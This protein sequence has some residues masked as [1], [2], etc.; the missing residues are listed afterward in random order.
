VEQM[1]RRNVIIGACVT[2]VSVA[3]LMYMVASNTTVVV[4]RNGGM[5]TNKVMAKP[6]G[7]EKKKEGV[8]TQGPLT[9][10]Q[11]NGVRIQG[12]RAQ[13]TVKVHE[14]SQTL[15]TLRGPKQLIDKVALQNDNGLL[16]I[17]T[18][19]QSSPGVNITINSNSVNTVVIDNEENIN[20]AVTVPRYTAIHLEDVSTAQVGDIEAPFTVSAG[21]S[22]EIHA[23]KVKD[24]DIAISGSGEV[25]IDQV[26][27]KLGIDISGSA[28]VAIP[29]GE[30]P[31][32][33]VTVSGSGDLSFGG[34]AQDGV[35]AISGSGSI[36]IHE[37]M[38]QPTLDISGNGVIDIGNWD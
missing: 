33:E 19:N 23:G 1:L 38:N 35:F 7:K 27:G 25:A 24:T 28:Q 4:Y 5:V 16:I 10:K 11:V 32:V 15:V 14:G 17:E 3:S 37:V 21:G 12:Y 22:S 2:A 8:I 29:K 6:G 30:V 20:I 26:S 13:V 9:Y 36:N 31:I 34:T 18:P